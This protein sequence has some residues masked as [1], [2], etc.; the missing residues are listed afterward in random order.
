MNA[1]RQPALVLLVALLVG[2]LTLGVEAPDDGADTLPAVARTAMSL[3]GVQLLK[4][5]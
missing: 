5:F 4:I 2:A 3:A 1:H